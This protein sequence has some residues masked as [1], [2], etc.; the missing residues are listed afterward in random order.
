MWKFLN[1]VLLYFLVKWGDVILHPFIGLVWPGLAWPGLPA[2]LGEDPETHSSSPF[3]V[4]M[5]CPVPLPAWPTN[6]GVEC[7]TN[8]HI[9]C[10]EL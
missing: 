8:I 2:G 7:C 9:L 5:G 3:M 6:M 4:F 1:L 10:L